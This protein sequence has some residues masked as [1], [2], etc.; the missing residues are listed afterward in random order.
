MKMNRGVFFF[1]WWAGLGVCVCSDN[2]KRRVYD[3]G[4]AV[5]LF[6]LCESF[7]FSALR[8]WGL[9]FCG[10]YAERRLQAFLRPPTCW[11]D[12]CYRLSIYSNVVCSLAADKFFFCL[13]EICFLSL[14]CYRKQSSPALGYWCGYVPLVFVHQSGQALISCIYARFR[15]FPCHGRLVS[16]GES[17]AAE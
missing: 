8:V 11:V 3:G 16:P 5:L 17:S 9:M 6:E 7:F 10:G 1:M 15:R 13:H 14:V 12:I 4:S 2:E